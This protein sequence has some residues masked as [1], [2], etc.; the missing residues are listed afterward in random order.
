MD[1]RLRWEREI[2]PRS[3]EAFQNFQVHHP[4]SQANIGLF[5]HVINRA[6]IQREIT[7][8]TEPNQCIIFCSDMLI[9]DLC[10]DANGLLDLFWLC[11]IG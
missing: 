10:Q 6:H 1:Q 4:W 8:A 2:E 11:I 7:E 3:I 5:A 9:N